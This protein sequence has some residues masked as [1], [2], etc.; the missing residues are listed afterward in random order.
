[1]KL[2]QETDLAYPIIISHEGRIMDGMHRVVRALIEGQT[3]IKAV[4]F[5]K[6]IA[7]DFIAVNENDLQYE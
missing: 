4:K 7:P 5:D 2:V 3:T 6:E 1:M